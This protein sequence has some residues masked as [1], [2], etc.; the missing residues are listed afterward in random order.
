MALFGIIFWAL[1]SIPFLYGV[2]RLIKLFVKRK[3]KYFSIQYK[4]L[5]LSFIV[6]PF[7]LTTCIYYTFTNAWE[8]HIDVKR[9]TLR[10]LTVMTDHTIN[11][12][13]IINP[14]TIA[15]YN[16][17]GGDGLGPSIGW[18]VAYSTTKDFEDIKTELTKFLLSEGY[19]LRDVDEP[20]CSWRNYKA[21]NVVMLYSG[22]KNNK[23]YDLAIIK[24]K[25]ETQVELTIL[26]Y[27]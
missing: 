10:W 16:H 23:C 15:Q 9:G 2:Y 6:I 1:M 21:S 24:N 3:A 5:T 26:E 4:I 13:P 14:K 27:D 20:E 18:K 12:F 25:N 11:N 8:S 22:E 7:C 19:T 17:I